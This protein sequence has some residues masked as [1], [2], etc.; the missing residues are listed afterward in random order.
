MQ[1]II[2]T[3]YLFSSLWVHLPTS[4]AQSVLL[5]SSSLS[6]FCHA[7]SVRGSRL[8]LSFS[9]SVNC[10]FKGHAYYFHSVSSCSLIVA[11]PSEWI[12][13]PDFF[14]KTNLCPWNIFKPLMMLVP[15]HRRFEE[16]L[17][18]HVNLVSGNLASAFCWKR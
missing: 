3:S 7:I 17:I 16:A 13:K 1:L 15:S 12:I 2:L 5:L 4:V 14:K 9:P 18:C 6:Y 11:L 8:C 10:Q